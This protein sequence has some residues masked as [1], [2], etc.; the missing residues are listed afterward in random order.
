MKAK[1]YTNIDSAKDEEWEF[2]MS[3]KASNMLIGFLGFTPRPVQLTE[4]VNKNSITLHSR[5]RYESVTIVFT[6]KGQVLRH[7]ISSAKAVKGYAGIQTF[8]VW[9]QHVL[10]GKAEERLRKKYELFL[11]RRMKTRVPKEKSSLINR[12]NF[13][14]EHEA[15]YVIKRLNL[16]ASFLD[17]VVNNGNDIYDYIEKNSFTLF[18]R[19]NYECVNIV[20]TPNGQVLQLKTNINAS[21]KG[22]PTSSILTVW[23]KSVDPQL[24]KTILTKEIFD[25][26]DGR[27]GKR[28]HAS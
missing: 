28:L 13:V 19:D 24:A 1:Q 6:P 20:L 15:K 18:S 14:N 3:A 10:P 7:F 26:L 21:T 9:S 2:E 27:L 16:V 17:G 4:I 5:D 25:Y 11:D 12:R 23:S 22:A 8:N